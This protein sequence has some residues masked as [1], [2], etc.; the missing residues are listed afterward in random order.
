MAQA[1]FLIAL[2][3]G[4][5]LEY[6]GWFFLLAAAVFV[7]SS[8]RTAITALLGERLTRTLRRLCFEASLRQPI[9]YFDDPRNSVGRLTTRLAT[10]ASLVK[11]A[12]GESL[13]S[14][15]EGVACLVCAFVISFIASAKLTG[16]LLAVF[17][18]LIIGSLFEFRQFAQQSRASTKLLERSGEIVGD[19]VSAS[20]TVAAFNLQGQVLRLFDESLVEPLAQGTARGRV[21][22]LGAGFKQLVSI[23]AYALAF[24][25]GSRFIADGSLSF[26]S[27]M[28][29]FLA[30]TLSAEAI[31]RITSMAPDTAKAQAAARSI[32]SVIDRPRGGLDP[33]NDSDTQGARPPCPLRGRVEFRGV[34]FA[35]PARPDVLVLRDFTL[36]IEPGQAP[37]TPPGAR[38]P[39]PCLRCSQRSPQHARDNEPH[40]SELSDPMVILR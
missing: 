26:N 12:T 19:A 10:E 23:S 14:A 28:R 32:F 24:Y 36:T 29:V 1:P 11:G 8:S 20:R 16:V 13:G 39:I 18:L 9:A 33:L 40:S 25:A 17:P 5:S 3:P 21:L 30:V 22:G 6:L 2:H 37:P 15:T 31:G 38:A 27:L 34:C 35:Y 4:Q 7:A